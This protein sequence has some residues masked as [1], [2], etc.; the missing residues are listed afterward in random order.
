MLQGLKSVR[1]FI[2]KVKPKNK[3]RKR[4]QPIAMEAD[5]EYEPSEGDAPQNKSEPAAEQLEDYGPHGKEAPMTPSEDSDE[6][7]WEE[8]HA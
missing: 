8:V 4:A 7:F 3:G 2:L 1:K 6:Q 5:P